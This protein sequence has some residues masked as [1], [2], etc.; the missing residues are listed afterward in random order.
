MTIEQI[1]NIIDN[2]R[3]KSKRTSLQKDILDTWDVLQE[4]PFDANAAQKQIISNNNKYPD[5]FVVIRTMP[6]VVQKPFNMATE[7]DLAFNLTRQLDALIA[8]ELEAQI[9]GKKGS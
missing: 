3:S 8:K 4:K 1:I 7:T 9:N 5:T 2:L 6:D